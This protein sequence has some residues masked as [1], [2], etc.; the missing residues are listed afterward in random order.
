VFAEVCVFAVVYKHQKSFPTKL[1]DPALNTT[2][3]ICQQSMVIFL[4]Q[5]TTN[6]SQFPPITVIDN[7]EHVPI[8]LGDTLVHVIK[9]SLEM[10]L[11]VQVGKLQ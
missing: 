2:R 3:H 11:C 4:F 5:T 7:M 9:V 8:L 10:D 1:T 6:V